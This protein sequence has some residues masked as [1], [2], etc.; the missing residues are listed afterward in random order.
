MSI[1][2]TYFL[3]NNT[4]LRNS[5]VNTAKSPVTELKYGNNFSKFIFQIDLEPLRNK[6]A[7]GDII[8]N[9]T[10]RHTI[11]MTNCIFGDEDALGEIDTTQ[12]TSSFD[13]IIFRLPQYFDEG[14]GYE[15]TSDEILSNN[16]QKLFSETPSNWYKATTASGWTTS[17]IYSTN[18]SGV[19]SADIIAVQHF[20]NGN[21]D[22][23]VDVTNYINNI[24]LSGAT[25]YGV[26]IAFA[27]VYEIIADAKYDQT[28][29][30]FTKYTNTF[31]EPYLETVYDD[32]I[33]DDRN[34]FTLGKSQNLYLYV[35]QDGQ[36]QDLDSAPIVDLLDEDKIP[37]PG[38]TGLTTTKVSKGVYKV[39]ITLTGTSICE[40][41]L[42][43]YDK[44]N[45]MTLGGVPLT[46]LTQKFVPTTLNER[47][48]FG[49]SNSPKFIPFLYGIARGEKI[50]R[51]DIRKVTV[52]AKEY[53]TNKSKIISGV[54][55]RIYIKEG[56]QQV[57]VQGWTPV[58]KT[59]KENNFYLDTSW[60][61]PKEYFID[62][63]VDY[64]GEVSTLKNVIDFQIVSER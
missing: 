60:L 9:S 28:V 53:L 33:Q 61:V 27:S 47:V 39:S 43:F 52:D 38:Y 13:L 20:D 4:I 31:F 44:W 56:R 10:T 40:N 49:T 21:E 57:E 12:R 58:N 11:N 2:R 5:Y 15:Y 62:V 63:K 29:S 35:S 36:R 22:L 64:N 1:Y 17:G 7:N 50:S 48:N 42:Y 16:K 6:I 14:V 18:I 51:G 41:K 26:G 24:I 45:G 8:V 37:I 19:T 59:A 54:S 55:Y 3:K 46:S 30:F 25:D 23:H 32:V 34:T